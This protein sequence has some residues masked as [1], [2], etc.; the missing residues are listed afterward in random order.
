[1]I[2]D[3]IKGREKILCKSIR[4][5]V[6]GTQVYSDGR[7]DKIDFQTIGSF[8]KRQEDFYIMYQETEETGMAGASTVLKIGENKLILNR[9]GAA[10]YRQI[11]EPGALHHSNYVT[12]FASIY[13]STL[14]EEMEINLTEQGGHITLKYNLFA[15]DEKVSDNMLEINIKEDTPQ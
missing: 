1:M 9:M 11:F 14:T 3:L 6:M 13:M 8:Q 2:D 7:V 5:Q 15:N 10:N 12:S 4:I